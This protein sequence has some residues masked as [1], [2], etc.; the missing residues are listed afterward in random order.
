[1]SFLNI[2]WLLVAALLIGAPA[3]A[4]AP[5]EIMPGPPPESADAEAARTAVARAKALFAVGDYGAALAEFTRAYELLHDDP[6]QADVLNNIA[7][8]YER[9]FRYDLAL[10]HYQRYLD[11]STAS[12]EDRAEV[13]AVMRSLR[14]LLGTV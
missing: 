14:D 7:V 3:A 10:T 12:A 5:A 1:M 2:A 6:R 4:Q 8:C 13:E 9:M 11:E